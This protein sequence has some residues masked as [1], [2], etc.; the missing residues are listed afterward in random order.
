VDRARRL[1]R[2]P[3]FGPL[4]GDDPVTDVPAALRDEVVS[5]RRRLGGEA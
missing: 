2:E 3:G 5:A 4:D 1:Y